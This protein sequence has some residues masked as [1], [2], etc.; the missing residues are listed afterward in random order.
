MKCE[1][2][3]NLLV[4]KTKHTGY[5]IRRRR[6]CASCDVRYS[7]IEV[8]KDNSDRYTEASRERIDYSFK[9]RVDGGEIEIIKQYAQNGIWSEVH[10]V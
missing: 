10:A 1:C 6:V 4:K 3:G 8:F 9:G 7:T 2:G 5:G